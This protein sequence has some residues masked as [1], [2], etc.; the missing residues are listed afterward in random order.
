L[1]TVNSP[2]QVCQL[3]SKQTGVSKY[4]AQQRQTCMKDSQST[5]AYTSS[6]PGRHKTTRILVNTNDVIT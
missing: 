2:E 5:S 1:T 4:A 3:T 6:E